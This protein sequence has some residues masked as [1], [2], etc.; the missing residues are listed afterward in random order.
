[1]TDNNRRRSNFVQTHRELL[2]NFYDAWFDIAVGK[3]G[4][5]L[6]IL[7]SQYAEK[8]SPTYNSKLLHQLGPY[9]SIIRTRFPGA[10]LGE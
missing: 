1:M 7:I 8:E 4:E 2:H 3:G 10:E 5:K 6:G 9:F